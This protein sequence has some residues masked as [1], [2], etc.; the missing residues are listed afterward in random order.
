MIKSTMGSTPWLLLQDLNPNHT[1]VE[2]VALESDPYMTAEIIKDRDT[3]FYKLYSNHTPFI[4]PEADPATFKLLNPIFAIDKNHVYYLYSEA[5]K[6]HFRILPKADLKSF[7]A[8]KLTASDKY[9]YYIYNHKY[10]AVDVFSKDE[11][12]PDC[13]FIGDDE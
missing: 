10:D 9:N 2:N 5:S 13:C 11:S 6:E 8:S 3:L 12:L 7:K 1:V 4:V